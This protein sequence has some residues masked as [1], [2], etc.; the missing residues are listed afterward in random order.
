MKA[1]YVNGVGQQVDTIQLLPFS[2]V[3]AVDVLMRYHI[4]WS[5]DQRAPYLCP[6]EIA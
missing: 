6:P 2:A 5:A 4:L 3:V 1:L